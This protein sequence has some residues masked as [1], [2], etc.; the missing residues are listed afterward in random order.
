M[1][2]AGLCIYIMCYVWRWEVRL[3]GMASG[4]LERLLRVLSGFGL[5][6]RDFEEVALKMGSWQKFLWWTG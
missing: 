1:I 3:G 5:G 2:R 6:I 4:L